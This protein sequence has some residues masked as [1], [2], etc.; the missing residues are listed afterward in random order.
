[1]AER[2]KTMALN[3]AKKQEQEVSYQIEVKRIKDFS[4]DDQTSIAVDMVVNGV[5]IYGAYYRAGQSK[6]G[7]EYRM[8][9]FP[10]K[11]GSDG[12]YYNH[13]YFKTTDDMLD[14]I[15][16]QIDALS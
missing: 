9:A 1:M 11:K 10:S 3:K 6:D 13:V 2:N 14:E 8:I 16:K 5:M 4:K 15:E 12:K 7:K